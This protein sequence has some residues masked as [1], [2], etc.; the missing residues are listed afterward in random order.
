MSL[1]V[2]C[3]EYCKLWN[4]ESA[5]RFGFCISVFGRSLENINSLNPWSLS[6]WNP[7][8]KEN[9]VTSLLCFLV[10][11]YPLSLLIFTHL[12]APL[13]SISFH[14]FLVSLF[15]NPLSSPLFLFAPLSSNFATLLS[16]YLPYFYFSFSS[17]RLFPVSPSY[18]VFC[19]T[20]DRFKTILNPI[21]KFKFFFGNIESLGDCRFALGS[22]SVCC[23]HETGGLFFG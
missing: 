8:V 15:C 9:Q 16:S 19:E 13:P 17:S 5:V 23:H 21:H 6:L 1:G 10:F 2:F 7:G 12:T 14:S 11:F 20:P 4:Y 3:F 22:W 18:N